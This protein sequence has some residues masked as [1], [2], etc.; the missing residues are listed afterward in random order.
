M[1][2]EEI[3][4]SINDLRKIVECDNV[5]IIM[6][7]LKAKAMFAIAEQLAIYNDRHKPIA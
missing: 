7:S 4:E 2:L 6:E 1:S 3:T 5:N